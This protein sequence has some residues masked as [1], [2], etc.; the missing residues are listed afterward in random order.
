VIDRIFGV[1]FSGAESAGDKIWIAEARIDDRRI[2]VESCRP[3]AL[4]PGSGR[5]RAQ[6]LEA[7]V[8]LIGAQ[9]N[10]LV[11]CDFPFSLPSSMIDAR[12]WRAFALDFADRFGSADDF[13]EDC[14]RRGNGRELRRA[15]D[16]ESRVPFAAYNLRIY[17]QTY[18]GIR[19]FLAPLVRQRR[20][21]VLPME[22]PEGALPWVIETCPASTLK[23]A[24]LYPSYKGRSA[25][26]RAARAA[27]VRGLVR[28]NLVAPLE[29]AVRR[30]ALDNAGGDALDSIIAAAATA[31]AHLADRFAEGASPAE[32]MEGRVYF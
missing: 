9:R 4:L 16:R 2:R 32:S 12:D 20:A 28:R 3:A 13:L 24:G 21:V 1:D 25:A 26:A 6:C 19:D 29:P 30:L 15:C 10:S 11:G 27:I 14:R 23:H 7:L 18:H 17:R 22:R 5:K 31:R 8:D